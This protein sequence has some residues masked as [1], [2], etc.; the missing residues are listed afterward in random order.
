MTGAPVCQDQHAQEE[1]ARHSLK[2]E[3][4]GRQPC[5]FLA[6]YLT[7]AVCGS[8][9]WHQFIEPGEGVVGRG[10]GTATALRR[11]AWRWLHHAVCSRENQQFD[12]VY[13]PRDTSKPIDLYLNLGLIHAPGVAHRPR[14]L[15]PALFKVRHVPLHPAQDGRMS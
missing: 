7:P 11:T 8:G 9:T 15:V 4:C 5:S 12:P 6:V 14:V 13:R 1:C 3:R 10:G 2:N